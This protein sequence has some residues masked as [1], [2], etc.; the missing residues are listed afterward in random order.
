MSPAFCSLARLALP[1]PCLISPSAPLRSTTLAGGL[2][3]PCAS[4]HS[5]LLK[6]RLLRPGQLPASCRWRLGA[7]SSSSKEPSPV[8]GTSEALLDMITKKPDADIDKVMAQLSSDPSLVA[9]L[10][11]VREAARRVAELKA[12][13]AA[14]D[15]EV[16]EAP[17]APIE[18]LPSSAQAVA[19]QAEVLRAAILVQEAE[20]ELEAAREGLQEGAAP[21]KWSS[22]N[23]DEE[24]ERME[25]GKAAVGAGLAGTLAGLPFALASN[26]G[27]LLLLA[28]SVATTFVSCALFGV[29]Y[30][31]AVR[32]DLGN[33]QLKGGVVGAFGLVSGMAI[34]N[35]ILS[36]QGVELEN[37][38]QGTLLAGESVLTFAFGAAMLELAFNSSNLKPFGTAGKD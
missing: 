17:A 24:A 16:S 19:A 32:R 38:L 30:R 20:A 26:S 8:M 22:D 5:T 12:R 13:R 21:R 28:L 14:L 1:S 23:I 18:V 36:T 11:G 10:Q 6:W 34:G 4:A 33:T 25:S 27:G 37:V 3:P 7:S 31:Y 35:T 9:E 29:T 2:A 15:L